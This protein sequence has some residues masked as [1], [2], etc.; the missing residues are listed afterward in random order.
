M[1]HSPRAKWHWSPEWEPEADHPGEPTPQWQKGEDP[2][3]G[4]LGDSCH[5]AFCRDSELVQCI[6]QTYFRTHVLT[7]H[8]GDT[9]KLMEVF[10]EL[11]EMAGVL[12][13]EVHPVHDQWVGRKEL[14]LAYHVVRG[15]AK[16]LHF[17]RTVVPLKP[18]KIMGFQGIHSPKALKWQAGL[19]FCPWCRKE[20]QNKGTIVNHLCTRHYH[21]WLVC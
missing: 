12:G 21:L 19:S 13:T 15:S 16:D 17:F 7:F 1:V 18:P 9:Y 2:L 5:E 4:H 6:R 11:A 10:K 14:C 8:K 3:V 20:G